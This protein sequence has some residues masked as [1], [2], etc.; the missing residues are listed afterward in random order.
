MQ[1]FT[2]D[3]CRGRR[4]RSG[5]RPRPPQKPSTT[6]ATTAAPTGQ[7]PATNPFSSSSSAAAA[8]ISFSSFKQGFTSTTNYLRRRFSSGDLSGE[9]DDQPGAAGDAP[10]AGAAGGASATAASAGGGGGNAGSAQPG[11]TDLSLNLRPSSATSAPSSPARSGVSSLLSR[12]ASLTGR[13]VGGGGSGGSTVV[14]PGKERQLTLLVVDDAH[15]DW[16]KHF[17]G[18]KVHGEWDVRVEQAEFKDLSIWASSEAGATVSM[19]AMRQGTK[20]VR[21]FRPDMVLVRQHVRDGSRDNRPFLLGLR[22]GGVPAVNSLHS[23]YNFQDKPWVFAQLQSAQRRLGREQF[24]LMEQ[25]FFPNHADMRRQ[26]PHA[27]RPPPLQLAASKFP[28]VVK[29]GH[30]HGGLGKVRVQ[31]QQEL[32]DVAGLVAL[33]GDYCVV[34]PFVEAKC[35]LHIQKIGSAY[36]CFVRKSISGHWKANVGSA[37]LEQVPLADRHRLWVDTVAELF[38]GLDIC[39]VE[40]IQAKDGR[41]FITEARIP[42]LAL[43]TL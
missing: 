41:E 6:T 36:K 23:L 42:S 43:V 2:K 14:G 3:R 8:K 5:R 22:L 34:E 15:T 26:P 21:S 30:A 33:A 13:V 40:A 18:R 1:F 32:Q 9:L 24:P 31:S 4:R 25:S 10:A 29:V 28:C 35:D 16:A 7:Y 20:V 19:A 11:D 37:M 17:R 39:A 12:G 38:G 27:S